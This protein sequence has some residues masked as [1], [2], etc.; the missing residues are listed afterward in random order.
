MNRVGGRYLA[1]PPYILGSYCSSLRF[2]RFLWT[3]NVTVRIRYT[4]K[5]SSVLGNLKKMTC[6]SNVSQKRCCTLSPEYEILIAK[7]SWNNAKLAMQYFVHHDANNAYDIS[8]GFIIATAEICS[9][10]KMSHK[11]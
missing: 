11:N 2:T 9:W 5:C 3:V 7:Q 8:S 1:F 6:K 4:A 10:C